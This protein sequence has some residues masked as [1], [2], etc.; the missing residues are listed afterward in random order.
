MRALLTELPLLTC[1]KSCA[2]KS[3]L[4]AGPRLAIAKHGSMV[5]DSGVV[6]IENIRNN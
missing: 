1:E 5:L 2:H 6:T 3:T 4:V